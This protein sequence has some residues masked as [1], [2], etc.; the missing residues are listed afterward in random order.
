MVMI[1]APAFRDP[2][3]MVPFYSI[4]FNYA[5]GWPPMAWLRSGYW[6]VERLP[7][8]TFLMSLNLAAVLTLNNPARCPASSRIVPICGNIL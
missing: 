6:V 8:M 2:R 5:F 7:V 1:F 4:L 3:D